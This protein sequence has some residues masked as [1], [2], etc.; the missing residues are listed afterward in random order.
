MIRLKSCQQL[1]NLHITVAKEEPVNHFIEYKIK[2]VLPVKQGKG[3]SSLTFTPLSSIFVTWIKIKGTR[4]NDWFFF[5][6]VFSNAKLLCNEKFNQVLLQ[7][8]KHN[9]RYVAQ[10]WEKLTTKQQNFEL[11]L[12]TTTGH[13]QTKLLY[14]ALQGAT[15]LQPNRE[16]NKILFT[17]KKT[18]KRERNPFYNSPPDLNEEPCHL[19]LKQNRKHLW[20]TSWDSHAK[21]SSH[22]L[23]TAKLD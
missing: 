7:I 17:P 2:I 18:K 22:L 14:M 21:S 20:G 15:S 5:F 12:H 19:N 11:N 9:M 8:P 4:L 6:E 13:L 1:S 23:N 16:E 10:K 3:K